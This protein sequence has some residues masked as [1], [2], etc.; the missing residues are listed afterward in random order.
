MQVRSFLGHLRRVLII[1]GAHLKG[2]YLGTM[3]LAVAMDANNQIVPVAFGVGRSESGD[4]W[5][6]FL[7]NLKQCIGELPGLVFVSD[8]ANSIKQAINTVYPTA[9]HALCC[10]HLM[11]NVKT[12]DSRIEYKKHLYMKVCKAHTVHDFDRRM[13]AL[14]GALPVG[15]AYL[16]S[17]GNE[18]WSRAHFPGMRYNIMTSNSAESVNALCRYAR[19]LPIVSLMD[20]FRSFQQDW[21][22]K[23]RNKAGYTLM[24]MYLN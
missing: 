21:Y 14:H 12:K 24:H 18:R 11:M 16:E 6:W 9:H 19:K 23:R 8:R 15:A 22:A 10:R 2:P 17:I 7:T 4:G 5:A 3:Y 13:A 20:Y 1:D